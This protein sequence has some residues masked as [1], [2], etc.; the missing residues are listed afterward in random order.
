MPVKDAVYGSGAQAERSGQ[1]CCEICFRSRGDC[2]GRRVSHKSVTL[3]S[4]HPMEPSTHQDSLSSS[5]HPTI[6]TERSNICPF[7]RHLY[8]QPRG[9]HSCLDRI[10]GSSR[11]ST[12]SLDGRLFSCQGQ[13]PVAPGP[14]Q[15]RRI[16][17]SSPRNFDMNCVHWSHKSD[18]LQCHRHRV[19]GVRIE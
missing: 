17:S 18:L 19:C 10:H 13:T 1:A 14:G 9:R 11:P 4:K 5:Q 12:S 15:S 2:V 6:L 16:S 7:S 8:S 3:G